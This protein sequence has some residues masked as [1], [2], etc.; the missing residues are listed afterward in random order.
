MADTPND[1]GSP[2]ASTPPSAPA[3][4]PRKEAAPDPLKA[5]V[6]SVPLDRLRAHHA[7]ALGEVAY[8]AGQPSVRVATAALESVLRFLRDD[9]AC[10]FDLLIDLCGV[11]W[12]SPPERFEVNYHLYSIPRGHFLRVK[13]RFG[14]GEAAP[15]ATAIW[16]T[17]EWFE[18]EIFD[19]LGLSFAGHPD[20]RRILL[21]ENWRGHPLRKEY[22]L[23]GYPDQHL[24]LR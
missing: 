1:K 22:P 20:L 7:E 3:P 2:P 18:R 17:A 12:V 16:S 19:L 13:A 8:H 21:P 9:E 4:P 23:A 10:R 24:R 15:T 14:E 5:E 6:A 11:D